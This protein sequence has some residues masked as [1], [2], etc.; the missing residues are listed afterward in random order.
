MRKTVIK[1]IWPVWGLTVLLVILG[2]VFT[3]DNMWWIFSAMLLA[4]SVVWTFML[5]KALKSHAEDNPGTK[6]NSFNTDIHTQVVEYFEN[7]SKAT[8]QEIP[9]LLE[10]MEQLNSVVLDANMKLQQSFN[11]LTENSEQQS[12]LTHNIIE[13]L[14]V[15][16][17][18]KSNTL[19]FDKFTAETAQVLGGYVD[20]TVNVSDKGVEAANKMQ[21][22]IGHMD[23]MF[24][25]L[26]DVKYIA[27]QTGMLALNASIE[28]ARAGDFGRGF[29]VVANEVRTLAERSVSLNAQIHENVTLSRET[30]NETNKIVGQIA[31][32]K[33]N[34]ALD[35]KDNLDNMIVELDKVSH[36]VSESLDR[37]S[38]I[39]QAI[40]SDV[41]QAVMALQ[42]EDVASQLNAHVKA[43]LASLGGDIYS[44]QSALSQN[45]ATVLL[46][47][48]NEILQK[49][50][51]NKPASRRAVAMA[52][53][54]QG[55]VDLF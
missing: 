2:G 55:D 37:S 44:A 30:L 52:S 8:G 41:A 49:Q 38:D 22:M 15:E 54:E 7:L 17:E 45:D 39:T 35:A 14:R 5:N 21:D 25:L 27:D 34:E 1:K 42:Y 51:Q 40:Q 23:A 19:I 12:Q 53:M 29:S 43:W 13:Q 3:Q 28:A 16:D 26:E 48:F 33:M 20:L 4:V 11:G 50:I 31:S 47:A 46:R 10:S 9:P 36:F 24:S 18:N 32:L 6:N